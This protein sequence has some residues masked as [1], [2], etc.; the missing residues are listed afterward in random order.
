MAKEIGAFSCYDSK[1]EENCEFIKRIAKEDVELYNDM[2]KYGRRNISLL[3]TAPAGTV[4]IQTQTTSGI[5]PV[6]DI[7][8]YTRKKKVNPSDKDVRVD[9]VDQNGDSWQEF[10]VLHPKLQMWM[11]V[12]GETDYKKSPWHGCGANDLDWTQRVKLQAA[13]QRHVDHSISSTVNLPKNVTEEKVA[14]IYMAAW[15]AGCKGITVYRDGCRSGVLVREET[16]QSDDTINKTKAPKRPKSLKGAIH[17][18]K[19]KGENYYVAVGFLKDDVYEVFTGINETKNDKLSFPKE[20][21]DGKIIKRARGD[22]IFKDTDGHEYHLINGHNDDNADALTRMISASLRHGVDLNFIVHQLEKTKGDMVSFA[23]VLAR[24][25]KKYI[26]DGTK[27]H[28]ELCP[29]C[30]ADALVRQEGCMTC[31]ACGAGKCG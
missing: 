30:G 4:S 15:E 13:A 12:T 9:S 5:E 27:V 31:K 3:T 2:V 8:P 20:M 19:V 6:F 25:I 16:K 23:K 17:H 26:K 1:L 24:T 11:D 14:E 7:K 10:P 18:F 22:Y 28:G 29:S 21:H